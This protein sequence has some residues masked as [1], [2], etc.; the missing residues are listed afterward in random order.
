[1]RPCT[2]CKTPISGQAFAGINI[3]CDK[4][5]ERHQQLE[6]KLTKEQKRLDFILNDPE[7]FASIASYIGWNEKIKI[8]RKRLDKIMENNK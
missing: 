7:S 6:T 8:S 1:M 3:I 2:I 5:F 4:C